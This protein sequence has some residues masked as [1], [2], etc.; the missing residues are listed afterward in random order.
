MRLSENNRVEQHGD[1]QQRRQHDAHRRLQQHP[2]RHEQRGGYGGGGNELQPEHRQPAARRHDQ[3]HGLET[4]ALYL[5]STASSVN[6]LQIAGGATTAA[7]VLSAA[8]TDTNIGLTL[9]TKG[10]GSILGEIGG[11]TYLTVQAPGT[12]NASVVLNGTAALT[13]PGGTVS[14]RPTSGVNGMIRYDSTSTPA[15][16]AYV[17]GNWESLVTATGST[18]TITL[19]TQASTTNPQVSGDATT[20]FYTSGAGHVDVSASGAQIVDWSSSGENIVTG[21][22]KLAGINGIWQDNTNFNTAVGDTALP[23]T[24]SQAGGG[25]NGQGNLAVGYLALNANTTGN[26]NI[27]LG[28][29]T[30]ESNT[31]GVKNTAVGGSAL[32]SNTVG[33][34]NTALG[35][36]ALF[37]DT[38]G[39]NNTAVEKM[40]CLA[41]RRA[42]TTRRWAKAQAELRRRRESPR[43][44]TTPSLGSPWAAR[45]S[46]PVPT[47][48]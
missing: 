4:E 40:P 10:S 29:G 5:Q 11:T 18:S 46:P 35:Q 39:G 34:N 26:S 42:R 17:N 8:G 30:L 45:P 12:A 7:P 41:S 6:Y 43:A 13:L 28:A 21:S 22:L 48:Y 38:T 24:V 16:E 15:L 19:G 31:T 37:H 23:T 3:Q 33:S 47:I 2:D 20:G 36:Q 1:R 44:P 25:T 27:A 14:Q 32:L 9:N